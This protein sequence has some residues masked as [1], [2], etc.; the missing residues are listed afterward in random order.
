[1]T[2][3]YLVDDCASALQSL[4][5]LN[6]AARFFDAALEEDLKSIDHVAMRSAPLIY[7]L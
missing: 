2:T 5:E 7:E 1:M 3:G 4:S 6:I